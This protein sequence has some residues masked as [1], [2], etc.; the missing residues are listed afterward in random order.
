MSSSP[1]KNEGSIMNAFKYQSI[2]NN[3]KY[4]K[5]YPEPTFFFVSYFCNAFPGLDNLPAK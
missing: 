5:S 3:N 2:E 4:T 1:E